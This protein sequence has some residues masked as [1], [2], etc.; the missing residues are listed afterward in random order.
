MSHGPENPAVGYGALLDAV[1]GLRWPARRAVGAAP[2]GAHR[3]SQR[4][5]AGEFT[6]YRLYRQGDDPRALDWKLLGRSDRAFIKLSDDRA[7]LTTWVV[8]DGSASMAFPEKSSGS[9]SKFRMA[10]DVAIGLAAVVHASSDPIGVIVTHADGVSRMPPRTRRGAVP[11]IA[12]VLDGVSC[13]GTDALTPTVASLSSNARIVCLTDCLGDQDAL[14]RA[15]AALTAAGAQFECVHVVAA[16]ELLLPS[17]AHL[18]RD[19]ESAEARAEGVVLPARERTAYTQA[20][21]A[22]RDATRQRWRAI[23]AGYTEVHTNQEPAR[24]VR[25]VV[26]GAGSC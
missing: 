5:T 12:R 17:G 24:A 21:G 11:E 22:F 18:V 8:V 10:C 20:F 14:L 1:R 15:A 25:A 26:V 2:P 3:S 7:L 9:R 6:E 19:P 23:G 16:E 4:G 13:G